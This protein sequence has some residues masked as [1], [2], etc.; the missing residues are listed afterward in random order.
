MIS[1]VPLSLLLD[2]CFIAQIP[3]QK[4]GENK[5]TSDA[6]VIIDSAV[7]SSRAI[8]SIFDEEWKLLANGNSEIYKALV[9]ISLSIATILVAFWSVGWYQQI[10]NN[11]FST[12]V[13][14]EIIYPI[15]II[16]MLSNNGALLA[17]ASLL[18]RGI[19]NGVN[20]SV[21][22]ITRNGV[23]YREAIRASNFNKAF[24]ANVQ[25]KIAECE[26]KPEKTTD[27]NGK[28]IDTRQKC[29]ERAIQQ[30]KKDA[31]NY[32]KEKGLGFSPPNLKFWEIPGEM[33]NSA[34]QATLFL[35]FTGF[36]AA[37]QFIVQI[38]FLL[39]AYVAPVFL[40]MS[41]F[42][43]GSRPI[44]TWL[45]GWLT[46]G[47]ILV[48]YSIM[49]GLGAS[50]VVNNPPTNPLFL[51]LL[52]GLFSPLLAIGIGIGGGISSLSGFAAITRI[53]IKKI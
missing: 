12:I 30:A 28:V 51:P 31:D 46:L 45:S 4:P 32:R 24:I 16:L 23:T 8:V 42:P 20:D 53:I 5:G 7:A 50:A 40:V 37:F 48:S 44:F 14:N 35:V 26:S 49:V 29:K 27:K 15:I 36:E 13:I 1:I 22:S 38:A 2:L 25:A 18:F 34:V 43:T 47:L 9:A 17:N 21:L 52:H 10:V 6:T 33:A 41:L 19:S 11:G 39:N 3:G